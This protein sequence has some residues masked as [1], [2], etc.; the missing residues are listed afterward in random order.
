MDLPDSTPLDVLHYLMEAN[1]L[2]QTDLVDVIG[3]SGV[4]SEII[5]G[6]REISKSQARSLSKRFNVSYKLFL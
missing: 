5:D 4:V 2:R 1:S 6:K 3:S